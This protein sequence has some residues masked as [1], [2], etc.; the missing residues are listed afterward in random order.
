[1][2]AFLADVIVVVHLLVVVFM[3]G[4]LLAVLAGGALGWSWVRSPWWRVA[5][6]AIMAYIAFNAVRG[7]LCFLTIW[8]AELR[9]SAG[10]LERDQISFI[11]RVFRD[12]LYVEVPQ[13]TL[14]RIY[15]VF[16]AMVVASLL[17][18]RPRL[19]RARPDP[20]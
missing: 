9:R 1:M 17:F 12:V 3:I 6:L 16:G 4:G 7:E 10:Q 19:G 18:V 2:E 15:L 5:H 11:G 14:D 20:R 13:R 8:E